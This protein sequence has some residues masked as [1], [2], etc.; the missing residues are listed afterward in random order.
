MSFMTLISN[1]KKNIFKITIL[2]HQVYTKLNQL[3]KST[4]LIAVY[5]F[6]WFLNDIKTPIGMEKQ[7][8][9]NN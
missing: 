3:N 7:W 5:N 9:I 1:L 8:Y 4:I 6:L 2:K